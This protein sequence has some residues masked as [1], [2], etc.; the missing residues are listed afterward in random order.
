M[1]SFKPQTHNQAK[2]AALRLQIADFTSPLG[3]TEVMKAPQ[4]TQ[5]STPISYLAFDFGL[6]SSRNPGE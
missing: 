6:G 4:N 3:V 5:F 1:D 2:C